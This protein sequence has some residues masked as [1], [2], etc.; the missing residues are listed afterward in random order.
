MSNYSNCNNWVNVGAISAGQKNFQRYAVLPC[1]VCITERYFA[2]FAA[3]ICSWGYVLS[4]KSGTVWGAAHQS[5]LID[6]PSVFLVDMRYR[7]AM[8][9]ADLIHYRFLRALPS[10]ILAAL[11]A[12]NIQLLISWDLRRISWYYWG[13][14]PTASV[15]RLVVILMLPSENYMWLST[16][17]PS[18]LTK[19]PRSLQQ[20]RAS[21]RSQVCCEHLYD[22]QAARSCRRWCQ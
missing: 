17:L 12:Q 9:G 1:G 8:V 20:F 3:P 13:T 2:I 6:K 15:F 11:A 10:S 5:P 4:L 14:A 21:Q 19:I 18:M 7:V 16:L 22:G